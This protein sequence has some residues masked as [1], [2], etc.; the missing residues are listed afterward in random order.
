M[1][2]NYAIENV[3]SWGCDAY[4]FNGRLHYLARSMGH[5]TMESTLY[6]YSL[7][8]GLADTIR[9]KTE[10]GFNSIVPEAGAA[11]EK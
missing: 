11:Y 1:R 8:P 7:V 4:E 9:E 6:Y 3:N 2:H 5:R 10:A